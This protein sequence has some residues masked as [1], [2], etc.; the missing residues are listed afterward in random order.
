MDF[1]IPGRREA[2]SPESKLPFRDQ[3]RGNRHDG[4]CR[5]SAWIPGPALARRPG[6]TGS[7]QIESDRRGEIHAR[8]CDPDREGRERRGPPH[9]V[10]CRAIERALTAA[11]NEPCREHAAIARECELHACNA[12]HAALARF[13]RIDAM[14]G[15][16]GEH[17][18]L[19]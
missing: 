9:H 10:D 4:M 2:A 17:L 5:E 12:G 7:P 14:A 1:V 18:R 3:V 8:L 15:E 16:V 19:I 13:G 11:A 6:M